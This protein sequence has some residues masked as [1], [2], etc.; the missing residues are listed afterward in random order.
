MAGRIAIAIGVVLGAV[1]SDRRGSPM[2][3]GPSRATRVLWD[4]VRIPPAD[5]GA[6]P[7]RPMRT[8]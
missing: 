1:W 3:P 8:T 2:Q 7:A 5:L 6:R 4:L